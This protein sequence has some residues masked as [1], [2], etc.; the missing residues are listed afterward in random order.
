MARSTTFLLPLLLTVLL[1]TTLNHHIYVSAVPVPVPIPVSIIPTTTDEPALT[2]EHP[3]PSTIEKRQLLGGLLGGLPS[4]KNEGGNA[5][6]VQTPLLS[7]IINFQ[8]AFYK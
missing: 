4:F 1:L 2:V 3:N 8:K 5:G 6:G 7:P